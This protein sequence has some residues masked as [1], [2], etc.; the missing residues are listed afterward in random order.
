MSRRVTRREKGDRKGRK[1]EG[2]DKEGLE[3]MRMGRRDER[4]KRGKY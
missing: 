4:E 3:V 1:E 2:M